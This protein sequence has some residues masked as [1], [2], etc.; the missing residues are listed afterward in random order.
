MK[1]AA[2]ALDDRRGSVPS[3]DEPNEGYFHPGFRAHAVKVLL[4]EHKIT[5]RPDEMLVTTLGSCIAACV[6]DPILGL[7]G[8]NHF[9][10]PEAPAGNDGGVNAA[11]R[12]GGVAMERLINEILRRGGRRDRLEVKVFGGAK[13][14]AS[15]NPIGRRNA[16]FVLGFIAAEGLTLAAQDLGGTLA[17]RVHYFPNTGKVMRRLIRQEAVEDTIRSEMRFMSDL[18]A[19]PV[20]GDIELFGD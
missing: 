12:Y 20:E 9:L 2:R 14:I 4:G 8:M 3:L 19:K 5:Q 6:R 7:G 10:L 15:S 1:H 18:G 13:V 11:A 16:E 17:R